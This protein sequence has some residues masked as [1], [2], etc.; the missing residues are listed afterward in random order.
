MNISFEKITLEITR[1]EAYNLYSSLKYG[2]ETSV[3]EHWVNHPNS[4]DKMEATRITMLRE[5]SRFT[6]NDFEY[7]LKQIQD[8]LADL[9]QKKIF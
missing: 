4:F 3:K 7:D 9:V 2:L 1:D 8:L 5:L 6:G